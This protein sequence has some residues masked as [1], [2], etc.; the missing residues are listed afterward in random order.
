MKKFYNILQCVLNFIILLSV[1]SYTNG[2]QN[3]NPS[4][5]QLNNIGSNTPF[6]PT[7]D[8]KG[9][10]HGE[11][12]VVKRDG[13]KERV[14]FDK[15]TRRI[16]RLAEGLDINYVSPVLVAQDVVKGLFSGVTTS[17]L[18]NLASETAAYMSTEHPDYGKL[19]ARIAISNL[20]KD[21]LNSFSESVELLYHFVDPKTNQKAGFISNKVYNIVQN[22]KDLI[23]NK[24]DHSRDFLFDYFGFK[25]LEKSYLLKLNDKVIERPQYMI[26]RVALGIHGDDLDAAFE[27]YDLMSNHWFTHASPTLFHAGTTCQQMSSCFLLGLQGDSIDG[28][29][30]TLSQCALIS[31]A[32]GGI[33]LNIQSIRAKGSYIKGTR[34]NSNGLVPMLRVFDA[35]A[36]YVDQGGGKR[37]GAFAVYI[38][39]WHSDIFEVLD[40]KKNTGK[41][42]ARA[43]DLFYGLW[44][45]DLF[46]KRV[47]T[48]SE[49][50]LM[51][52]NECA[53]LDTCWGKD[54]ES[55]YEKY[56]KEG[57]Y[58]RKIKARELWYAILDAQ[59]ETGTP[60]MLYK[61]AANSKSNQQ[62]LGT[63]RCSNLCTE[64]IEYTSKDE[65]AV[66]NL[67]SICLPK[68]VYKNDIAPDSNNNNI[69]GYKA[70]NGSYYYYDHNKLA[71]VIKVMVKNL[72]KIIDL[73][74][75]PL[76][77]AKNSNL[78]HR[79]VGLGVQGL[80]DVFQMM[81]LPFEHEEARRLNRD[82][83]QTIYY[84]ALETS[85]EIAQ[86]DGKY[87]S[88]QG[89]PV[90]QGLLQPDLW[91][92]HSK[93]VIH[94]DA[95]NDIYS[96]RLDWKGLK[97]N[98]AKYG[99][100]NSLLVAPMPTASTAQILG[101][102]E[103]IEPYTSNMYVRRV[104]AGEFIVVN[105][106]LLNDLISRGLWNEN[107]KN[108]II[109]NGGSVKGLPGIS[110]DLQELYKTV[111]EIKQRCIIDLAAD[112]ALYI[113]QSQSLNLF[114]SQ[115][116]YDTLT[117]MH[118]Y[119]HKKGLKTGMYYLRT[120]GAS[121]AVQFTIDPKL[122]AALAN[123][124][125]EDSNG[126]SNN[127]HHGHDDDNNNDN[128][129]GDIS[130]SC[131]KQASINN[132]PE[133]VGDV[134]VSCGS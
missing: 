64:I 25:T 77:Q 115:A 68:F 126:N 93:D 85:C 70:P 2:N 16:T 19:A 132:L 34:G 47:E 134:C 58:R 117:S 10:A 81:R 18:D 114:V 51:C 110:K 7:T 49:W 102:N 28:I 74:E 11:M 43:R 71:N 66:C 12:I 63:I 60:Y 32:A 48:D 118:F 107:M 116:D 39:P 75:Y 9:G 73:N 15:I 89:S 67:A 62:N 22:N 55:L 53:G 83:F 105:P 56:E 127:N 106:H 8:I 52:P 99:I 33:G 130:S 120:K 100:R 80:A 87:S 91:M 94:K 29:Y 123:K 21:S 13:R 24:I 129:D 20:Q 121:S 78:K 27:T 76:E 97:E 113:D 86:I 72:N 45:P 69:V 133:I 54:F 3:I 31:K 84:S 1:L 101:N 30:D 124:E 95:L 119:A 6:N 41:E 111:W 37:P 65:I 122:Q 35:T 61:D 23:D 4:T 125:Y 44:I 112:R 88:F 59:I 42:E 50:C 104:R 38:E 96:N 17:E 46:M 98:I 92:L 128:D 36:R 90:S 108:M 5:N 14:S 40:L 82:I 131:K 109:A 26:M 103:C 79:P 57:K